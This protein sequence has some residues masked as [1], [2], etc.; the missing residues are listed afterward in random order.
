MAAQGETRPKAIAVARHAALFTGSEMVGWV[1]VPMM[2]V[3]DYLRNESVLVERAETGDFVCVGQNALYFHCGSG[4][5]CLVAM[6]V[7]V[8]LLSGFNQ[9][10]SIQQLFCVWK[11][12][13]R[14][15]ED[16]IRYRR[17]V[18]LP[19]VT[20]NPCCA[21][22]VGDIDEAAEGLDDEEIELGWKSRE[23]WRCR[24]VRLWLLRLV[25]RK[26]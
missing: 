23:R 10:L 6:V 16:L 25:K 14:L 15:G 7:I 17:G 18:E 13:Y 4:G 12:V 1:V 5:F 8:L 20:E 9:F 2:S 21:D 22:K 3:Q 11:A 26:K 24:A 19:Y